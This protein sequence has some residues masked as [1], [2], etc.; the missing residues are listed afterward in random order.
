MKFLAKTIN[1]NK[2]TYL[3]VS[4]VNEFKE[5]LNLDALPFIY[6]I[7]PSKELEPYLIKLGFVKS[8]PFELYSFQ[9]IIS[10]SLCPGFSFASPSLD[11]VNT[12]CTFAEEEYPEWLRHDPS[13]YINALRGK[14]SDIIIIEN[15]KK[16]IVGRIVTE[17]KKEI[18]IIRAIGVK[19]EYRRRGIGK[20][21]ISEVLKRNT[22]CS[23]ITAFSLPNSFAFWESIGFKRER[24]INH[25]ILNNQTT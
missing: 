24:T 1:G 5:D 9:G 2:Y 23:K 21:L 22:E 14:E 4:N 6:V 19:P 13:F 3:E 8:I 17:K 16:E 10:S 18:C 12:L 11:I 20:Y 25:Y 15:E 7:N